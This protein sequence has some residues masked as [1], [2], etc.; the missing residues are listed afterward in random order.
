MKPI[1][2]IP[3]DLF[4]NL[5]GKLL[6]AHPVLRDP[7]FRKTAVMLLSHSADDGA[8]GVIINRPTDQNV[9]DIVP[10]CEDDFLKKIPVYSGGPV[11]QDQLILAGWKSENR[12]FGMTPE[13]AKDIQGENAHLAS[14]MG[15]S[16]WSPGQLENEIQLG[17]WIIAD[18][19]DSPQ[20]G[21]T[22][23]KE[24]VLKLHP[25]LFLMVDAPEN[26]S[27]N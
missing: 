20:T 14:Y 23:W 17:T 2:P 22:L 4:E 5:A 25:E 6:L 12:F 13:T 8:V 3:E 19:T 27:L 10:A 9:G 11:L 24:M 15:Y 1:H 26:P 7:N 21:E 18:P 16:G